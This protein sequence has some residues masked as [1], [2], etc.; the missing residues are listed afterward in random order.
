[1]IQ[2]SHEEDLAE[3][4]AEH[5]C[6]LADVNLL[7]ENALGIYDLDVTLLIAQQSQKDP[8][9]YLPYLQS[10]QELTTLRR[11]FRIDNDLRRYQKALEHLHDLDEFEE[12]QQYMGKHELYSEAIELYKY[13]EE[14]LRK[15]MR[16]HADFLIGKNRYKEAGIGKHHC[17]L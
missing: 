2:A 10:L 12:L 9:E 15:L 3:K 14:R 1:M 17:T 7:Y 5:I 13:R 4:A 16:L 8:R 6:F 11:Q